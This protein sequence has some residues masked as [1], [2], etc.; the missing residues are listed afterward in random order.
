[1]TSALTA[2]FTLTVIASLEVHPFVSVT[3]TVYVVVAVGVAIGLNKE[4]L[5]SP[6]GGLH[7]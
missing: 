1:M 3:V 5:L 2:A 6:V 7:K 4:T